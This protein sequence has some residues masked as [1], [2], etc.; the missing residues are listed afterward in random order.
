MDP[1]GGPLYNS[2]PGGAAQ[3]G[4]CFIFMILT[5]IVGLITAVIAALVATARMIFRLYLAL[6]VWNPFRVKDGNAPAVYAAL[7]VGVIVLLV[8]LTS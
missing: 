4:G 5:L 2:R 6:V 1:F 8:W 3:G 7:V